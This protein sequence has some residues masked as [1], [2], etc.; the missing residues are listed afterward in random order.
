MGLLYRIVKEISLTNGWLDHVK[1][2]KLLIG[3]TKKTNLTRVLDQPTAE[4][5]ICLLFNSKFKIL[6]A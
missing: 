1:M 4:H 6:A 5:F 3:E 2:I